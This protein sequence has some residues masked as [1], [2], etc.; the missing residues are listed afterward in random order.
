MC[1]TYFS[2]FL[3]GTYILP[4]RSSVAGTSRRRLLTFSGT[5]LWR[6][7]ASGTSAALPRW[8]YGDTAIPSGRPTPL[9]LINSRGYAKFCSFQYCSGRV[10]LHRLFAIVGWIRSNQRCES[11]SLRI[12]IDLAVMKPDSKWECDPVPD[13]WA[14]KLTKINQCYLWKPNPLPHPS[15]RRGI[16]G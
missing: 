6:W 7:W 16:G 5:L 15:S 14:R 13:P 10:Y 9:I 2:I 3:S 1:V 4:V 11:G 8:T 12:R